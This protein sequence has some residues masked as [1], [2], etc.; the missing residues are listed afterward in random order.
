MLNAD[1]RRTVDPAR[2]AEVQ[3]AGQLAHD[4]Q[5]GSPGD[6]RLERAGTSRPG[7]IRAR[8]QVRVHAEALAQRQQPAFG[9]L[10]RGQVIEGRVAYRP[11][12]Y[13]RR[14]LTGR[15]RGRG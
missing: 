13:A 3:A 4:Q 7:Q 14:P 11:E 2:L 5:V 12:Q 6:L 10:G 15:E 9:P 1:A 8:A